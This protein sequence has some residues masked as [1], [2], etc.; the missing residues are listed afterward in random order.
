MNANFLLLHR[1]LDFGFTE[2][3]RVGSMKK[4]NKRIAP[5]VLQQQESVECHYSVRQQQNEE[6]LNRV[7]VQKRP[8]NFHFS[9]LK[10]TF[11]F[12]NL[13]FK[14]VL[15]S[16]SPQMLLTENS[17][18][19]GAAPNP[20]I[21]RC[22]T[23]DSPQTPCYPQTPCAEGLQSLDPYPLTGGRDDVC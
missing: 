4:I 11:K 23:K 14:I 9:P 21:A 20:S 2:F 8:S 15:L 1:L 18:K 17:P 12:L 13:E 10:R 5:Y 3:L 19:W 7:Q 22:H 6:I 16:T